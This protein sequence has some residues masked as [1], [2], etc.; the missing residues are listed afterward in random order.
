[1]S[2]AEDAGYIPTTIPE[3]MA[4]VREGVNEQFGTDYDADSFLGTNFYKFFYALVQQLQLQ[5]V[6]TSEIVLTLQQYFET[7]N[8]VITRPNTTHPGILDALEGASFIASTKK[9]IEADA[10]KLY[11]C[12]DL[13]KGD[14][15]EGTATITSY[16]NLVS[17]TDDSITVGATVFTAQAGA[18]TPGD[19]TFQAATSN[20]A[21]ALSLANQI[22][23]HA[24]AG[25]LVRASVVA[26]VVTIRA[27][28]GG[29]AGNAI[30][31]AYTDNDTNVGATVSGAF[32]AGGTDNE[33]YDADKL[34]ACT[35]LKDSVV[36]GVVTMGTETETIALSNDQ[37]FDWKF[38]LPDRI[39]VKLRLTIDVSDNNQFSILTD[40]EVAALL[41]ENLTARYRLGLNFEPQ[42]YFSILD[43]PWAASVLLEYSEDGGGTYASTVSALE[44]DELYD[45]AL[46]DISIVNT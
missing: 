26:A 11:V 43:A 15:A 18:A 31:L 12:L 20:A 27:K 10:G 14:R 4:L 32:L 9:P 23:S 17:G 21:T 24:T 5:E 28:A 41:L 8:E 38:Y 34:E 6:K 2:F 37:S 16:A 30:A 33:D 7:T 35:I 46:E 25:E 1:M 36:A 39:P 44:F 13:S 40:A 42:R 22:N 19:A 3:L 29:T 45:F